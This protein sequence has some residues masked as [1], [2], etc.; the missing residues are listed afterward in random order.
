MMR[1]GPSVTIQVSCEGCEH[2]R[3]S[4]DTVE[5]GNDVDTSWFHACSANGILKTIGGY[6]YTPQWCPRW[7]VDL[8][9][10]T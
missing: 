6:T 4:S 10:S 8:P 3:S 9:K 1:N 7:P 5:D 2:L